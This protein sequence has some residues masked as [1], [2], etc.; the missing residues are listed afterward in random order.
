MTSAI[1]IIEGIYV[2]RESNKYVVIVC[3]L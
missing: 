1:K 3:I 2:V